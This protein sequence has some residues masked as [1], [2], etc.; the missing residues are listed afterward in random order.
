MKTKDWFK[1]TGSAHT[2]RAPSR[3]TVPWVAEAPRL[4]TCLTAYDYTSAVLLDQAGIDVILVGDSLGSVIQGKSTTLPVTMDQ[5][6]YHCACVSVG[7]Q[8]A[9]VVGDMP[10]MSYQTSVEEAVRNAGRLVKEGG[11]SAVKLEGGSVVADAI[12]SIVKAEIPVM[13]HVGLT[14]Q[15]VNRMG[16]YRIQGKGSELDKNL[17]SRSSQQVI[18]DALAVEAA[19]A[20]CVVLEGVPAE[21]AGEITKI[22]TIPTIGI[23]AG[24]TCRG[25]ILVSH[26]MLGL[27]VRE[28]PKFVKTFGALGDAMIHSVRAYIEEVLAG[29]FP[30]EEHSYTMA[31]STMADSARSLGYDV[32]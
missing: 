32:V 23:G 14:P 6:T 13:G 31:D 17:R 11:V 16:G 1:E 20:F 9:L 2:Q 22:L 25:Q 5:M 26:D 12:H 28:L 30:G 24:K 10:F 18:D 4:I 7:V 19:G 8:R 3:V 29:S 27:S 21:L 15:S